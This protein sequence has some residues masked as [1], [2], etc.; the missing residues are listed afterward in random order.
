[1]PRNTAGT[2]NLPS[3][4][5]VNTGDTILVSQHNPPLQDIA[6]ALTDS[7]DRGGTGGMRA[8]LQM[9]GNKVTGLAPG[10][11]PDD[12]ATVS[13]IGASLFPPG[14]VADYAG[15]TPP[16]GWLLC[17]GQ[18]VSR[19]TYAALFAAIGTAYGAGDGNTTFNLPDCRGRVS[20][21]VDF[22]VGTNGN[23]LTS[24]TMNPNGTTLGATGG[25]QTVTLTQAQM[26]SHTHTGSTDSAGSHS[27]TAM[28][29]NSTLVNGGT[30][31]A[32]VL[33]S[34]GSTSAN[35]AHTHAITMNSTGG[36]EAH[37]NVQP[38]I[39]FNRIIKV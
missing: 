15:A 33:D 12:A 27:H 36:G 20:A 17:G 34:I 35:G 28:T 13:Q 14:F 2:Y 16:A 4:T 7:L 1:M 19:T 37:S 21:G 26:P 23:R 3:G 30:S 29:G 11:A 32:V 31:Q 6:Q 24:A 22:S 8:N 5:L 25:A 39:L 18:A 10:T 9:G 38:T